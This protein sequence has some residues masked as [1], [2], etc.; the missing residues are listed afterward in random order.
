M[1]KSVR[2]RLMS[3]RDVIKVALITF[4]EFVKYMQIQRLGQHRKLAKPN[5]QFKYELSNKKTFL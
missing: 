2:M 1:T 5:F 3:T 4:G